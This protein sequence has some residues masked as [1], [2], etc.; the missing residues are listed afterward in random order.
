VPQTLPLTL[1]SDIA[2]RVEAIGAGVAEFKEGDEVYGLTNRHF[3]GG[4]AEYALATAASMALK[5]KSLDFLAA[6]SAPV[7]AVTAWQ[8]LFDYAHAVAGERV[9]IHGGAGNVGAYALQLAHNAGLGVVT[10]VSANDVEYVGKLGA[11]VA[12]DHRKT[13]FEN[14][15]GKVDIVIDTVGGATRER[16]LAVLKSGGILVSTVS[17]PIPDDAAAKLGVRAVFF[18]VDVT[19]ARLNA[20]AQLFDGGKLISQVGT[21]LPLREAQTA[22]RMLAGAPHPRGKIVLNVDGQSVEWPGRS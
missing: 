2:G 8:M 7:V 12:I 20:V 6:A 17:P 13:P 16:S 5:P 4:Y 11:A 3:T 19:S 21:V 22:H 18:I 15:V 1:G 10:T 14:A 9:L